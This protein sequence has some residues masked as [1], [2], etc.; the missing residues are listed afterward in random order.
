MAAK[1]RQPRKT[2]FEVQAL[3]GRKLRIDFD[4]YGYAVSYWHKPEK[5]E[6]YWK[7]LPASYYGTL[8]GVV[9]R[10]FREQLQALDGLQAA[11]VVT[12]MNAWGDRLSSEIGKLGDPKTSESVTHP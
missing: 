4:Q 1:G 9:Q 6:P 7:T 10:L 8:G 11:Q 2:L 12:V 5:G 3:D